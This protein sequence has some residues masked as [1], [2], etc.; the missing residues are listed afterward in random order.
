MQSL[1]FTGA[2]YLSPL[3]FLSLLKSKLHLANVTR[4]EVSYHGSITVDSDLMVAV[5]L[6]AYEKVLVGNTANGLRGE[7]YVI[8]GVPGGREIQLNGAM[9]HLAR[10]G[11]RVIV[12][13]FA[14][15]TP[16]E[17]DRHHPKVAIL[18]DQ[19]RIVEQFEG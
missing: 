5:G 10:P 16:E 9:A 14:Q 8:P 18:D 15:M 7:T 12:M 11:D 1:R 19:N 6:R 4:T 13:S 3:M 2:L 17:A